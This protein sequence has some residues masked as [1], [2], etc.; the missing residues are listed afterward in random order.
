MSRPIALAL[1]AAAAAFA[2]SRALTAQPALDGRVAT[3]AL[4]EQAMAERAPGELLLDNLP[5]AADAVSLRLHRLDLFRA[6]FRL[7]V[8][9]EL[10]PFSDLSH[11]YLVLSGEVEQHPGSLAVLLLD[12]GLGVGSGVVRRDD[13]VWAIELGGVD[14]DLPIAAAWRAGA[15]P[16]RRTCRSVPTC[17]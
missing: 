13:E 16:S 5:L 12:R 4:L 10:R 7:V 1:I 2:D 3:A 6:D 11:R 14:E 9:G 8:D 15:S 17:S